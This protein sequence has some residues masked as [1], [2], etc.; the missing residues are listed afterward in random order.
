MYAGICTTY[1]KADVYIYANLDLPS[2]LLMK[3]KLALSL[4]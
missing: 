1:A 2:Q 4:T 3:A